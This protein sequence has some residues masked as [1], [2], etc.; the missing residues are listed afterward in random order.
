MTDQP[1]RDVCKRP[2][3]EIKSGTTDPDGKKTDL[4]MFTDNGQGFHYSKDTGSKL[5]LCFGTSYDLCGADI[6]TEGQPGKVIRAENGNIHIEA[7]NGEVVI[8][9]KSIRLVAQDGSGEITLVSG[10]QVAVNSPLQNFKGTIS[11]MVMSSTADTAALA[12][13][14][15]GEIQNSS[16]SGSSDTEGS[17]L[18]QLLKLSEKFKAWLAN[19]TGG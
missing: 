11:N 18:T 17:L 6:T 12:V 10:K 4:S 8:K 2:G 9:A 5:D 14:T 7:M 16:T 1:K 19:C 13:G 15:R 3:Y